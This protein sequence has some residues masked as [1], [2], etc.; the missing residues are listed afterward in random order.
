MRAHRSHRS[1]SAYGHLI[2]EEDLPSLGRTAYRCIEH[3]DIPYSDLKGIEESHF[4]PF[5]VD[6]QSAGPEN[7]GGV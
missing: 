5:H 6:T 1:H 7:M 2:M 3:P 4:K